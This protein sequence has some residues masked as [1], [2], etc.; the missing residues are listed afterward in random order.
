[1]LDSDTS[2][3]SDSDKEDGD[4]F[5]MLRHKNQ[6]IRSL[7]TQRLKQTLQSYEAK[8]LNDIDQKL[9][10]GLNERIKVDV[11]QN[12]DKIISVIKKYILK[13]IDEEKKK[14]EE[15]KGYKIFDDSPRTEFSDSLEEDLSPVRRPKTFI[16]K[17]TSKITVGRP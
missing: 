13:K 8:D 4:A 16:S 5:K 7:F 6:K 14:L 11:E 1:M 10:R 17:I 2:S 12:K 9:L 3:S 15:E